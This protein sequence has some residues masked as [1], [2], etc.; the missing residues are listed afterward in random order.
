MQ[1]KLEGVVGDVMSVSQFWGVLELSPLDEARTNTITVRYCNASSRKMWIKDD[2]CMER[3]SLVGHDEKGKYCGCF[4]SAI[5]VLVRGASGNSEVFFG[6]C[7]LLRV[8]RY[9]CRSNG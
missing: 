7:R 6:R 9:S 2:S 3:V 4:H 1:T 5:G 8:W